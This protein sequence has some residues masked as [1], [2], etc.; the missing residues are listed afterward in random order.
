MNISNKITR[1]FICLFAFLSLV[2]F[3]AKMKKKTHIFIYPLFFYCNFNFYFT[4]MRKS[5][6]R[7][8][9][10]STK[11]ENETRRE[12]N[13]NKIKRQRATPKNK[14]TKLYNGDDLE[15]KENKSISTNKKMSKNGAKKKQEKEEV[16]EEEEV[17]ILKQQMAEKDSKI[18]EIMQEM[19]EMQKAL[20]TGKS[21]IAKSTA[22]TA[23]KK[24][25]EV[26]DDYK[27]EEN[28]NKGTKRKPVST[29]EAEKKKIIKQEFPAVPSIAAP[30][31]TANFQANPLLSFLQ[32]FASVLQPNALQGVTTQQAVQSSVEDVRIEISE[33]KS[34]RK[35]KM[36]HPALAAAMFALVNCEREEKITMEYLR[37]VIIPSISSIKS[38]PQPFWEEAAEI[39]TGGSA[40]ITELNISS[41]ASGL[42]SNCKTTRKSLE[43]KKKKNN[44]EL[45]DLMDEQTA[46]DLYFYYWQN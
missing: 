4:K 36:G 45:I 32:M 25:E 1:L 9:K 15:N 40:Q 35:I 22:K 37:Q 19:R 30:V 2:Y 3:A 6:G 33:L 11:N 13:A 18:E 8:S 34:I 23:R 16:E 26:D 29:K 42:F 43:E 17:E 44:E 12:S 31:N 5:K 39:L 20:E 27:P 10:K 38:I 14:S 24:V 46:L 28:K 21:K 41:A 7:P